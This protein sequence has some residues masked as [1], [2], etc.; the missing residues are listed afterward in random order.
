MEGSSSLL[1]NFYHQTQPL[2][3]ASATAVTLS[4]ELIPERPMQSFCFPVL[5]LFKMSP[6]Q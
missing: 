4:T 5:E 2:V 3:K 6:T 1:Q